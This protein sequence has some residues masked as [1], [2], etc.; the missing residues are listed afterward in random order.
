MC[1]LEPNI[2]YI[3]REKWL[4][5]QGKEVKGTF[6][7]ETNDVRTFVCMGF[8]AL[9]GIVKREKMVVSYGWKGI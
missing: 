5:T 8:G 1:F 6:R 3:F 7:E 2:S 4:I 9:G